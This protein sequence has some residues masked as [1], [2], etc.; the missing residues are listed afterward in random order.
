MPHTNERSPVCILLYKS[1]DIS[2]GVREWESG[3]VSEEWSGFRLISS[4]VYLYIAE[5]IG[6]HGIKS[7]MDIVVYCDGYCYELWWTELRS[8]IYAI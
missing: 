7:A 5:L 2:E 4:L 8:L 1:L 6:L 3:G